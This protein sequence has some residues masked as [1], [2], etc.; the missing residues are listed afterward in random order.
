MGFN[1]GLKGLTKLFCTGHLTIHFHEIER[2]NSDLI[3][4]QDFVD[5]SERLTDFQSVL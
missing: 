1:S 3:K 4:E 5:K 2:E